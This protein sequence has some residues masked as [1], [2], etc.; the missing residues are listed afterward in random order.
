[1]SSR[2]NT[3]ANAAEQKRN[4]GYGLSKAS[5]EPSGWR[6]D[7]KGWRPYQG[8]MQLFG[9]WTATEAPWKAMQSKNSKPY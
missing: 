5:Q 9:P 8:V 2:K 7:Q 4:L 6:V 3:R 1:L